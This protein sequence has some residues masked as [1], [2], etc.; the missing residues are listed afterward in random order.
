MT[1]R[2]FK[3]QICEELDGASQYLK[4]A[5]DCVKTHPEWSKEFKRMSEMEQEHA[6]TLYKMFMEMYTGQETKDPWM[7]QM[8]DAIMDCFSRQMRKIE[9]LKATYGLMDDK[10]EK[11]ASKTAVYIPSN[12]D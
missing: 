8:R 3:E 6:T 11:G 4:K 1:P 10:P 9:D 7:E 2:Y 5:I 12:N